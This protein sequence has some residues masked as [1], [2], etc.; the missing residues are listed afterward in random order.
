MLSPKCLKFD[1]DYTNLRIT[2]SSIIIL[3]CLTML[4]L[5]YWKMKKN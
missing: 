4:D 3:R 5:F 1:I 2:N